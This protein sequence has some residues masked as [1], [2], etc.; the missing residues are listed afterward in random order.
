MINEGVNFINYALIGAVLG[1]W[2][3]YGEHVG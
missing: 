3:K 1:G 2:R